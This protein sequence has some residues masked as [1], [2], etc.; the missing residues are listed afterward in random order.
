MDSRVMGFEKAM[1]SAKARVAE[2]VRKSIETRA[3]SAYSEGQTP[4]APTAGGEAPGMMEKLVSLAQKKIDDILRKEGI[5]SSGP[6]A[7]AAAE[8]IKATDEFQR[9]IAQR[10][11]GV[12]CG[13]AG[14][15]DI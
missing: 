3:I 9:F 12:R 4:P 2:Y 1:L 5:D 14:L 6:Q 15:P 8:K 10:I 11:P 13:F 7:K